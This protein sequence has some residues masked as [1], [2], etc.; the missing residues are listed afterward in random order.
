MSLKADASPGN[1]RT[2]RVRL[3]ISSFSLSS[4]LVVLIFFL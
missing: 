2:T 4:A 3:L 1:I